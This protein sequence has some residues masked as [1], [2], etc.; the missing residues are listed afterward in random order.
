MQTKR[1]AL[2]AAGLV[3]AAAVGAGA[4][5]AL[6]EPDSTEVPVS[7]SAA[8]A[9]R[10][11]FPGL[12]AARKEPTLA[13]LKQQDPR[14][15]TVVTV[16]GPFD[17]RFHFDDLALADGVLTGS[18]SVT[19]DVSELLELQVLAGFYARDGEFLG[20]GRFV[21][22]LDESQHH[23]GPPQEVERFR[24]AVPDRIRNQAVSAAV[25]VP[26]LVNE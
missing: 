13:G 6:A 11:T 8:T 12:A 5:R 23:T 4:T 24:I 15:G 21:H 10:T 19:S 14:P 22:H 1:M 18:V 2:A 3:A 20:S 25:G 26:V 7:R 17:D 16:T 9:A